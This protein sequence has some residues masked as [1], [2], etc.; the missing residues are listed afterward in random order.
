MLRKQRKRNNINVKIIPQRA[1]KIILETKGPEEMAQG[2]K[3]LYCSLKGHA[4]RPTCRKTQY[5]LKNQRL[6]I[7]EETV[8]YIIYINL[9]VLVFTLNAN[10]QNAL[11]KMQIFL[12]LREGH[13]RRSDSMLSLGNTLLV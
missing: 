6:T 3:S 1:E 2:V 10:D 13:T 5:A 7:T 9:A 4:I 8:P 11:I 12:S